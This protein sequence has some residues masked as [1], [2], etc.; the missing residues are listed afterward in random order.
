[1]A[2]IKTRKTADGATRYTAIV[3][4]RKGQVI[5]HRE[6]KTFAFRSAA[7][8]WAKFREVE[9]EKPGAL[10]QA[11]QGQTSLA[12]LI[13][14]YIDS[15]FEIAAWQRTKQTSLEF[16]EK[17]HIGEVNALR[18]TSAM[19]AHPLILNMFVTS[20]TTHQCCFA[21]PVLREI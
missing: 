18:M 8:S 19:S 12:T 16:L 20:M 6:S 11:Q 14:W 15:F 5:L 1:M 21:E 9:L 3:R 2:T 10:D 4:I 7:L 17:H 13:R